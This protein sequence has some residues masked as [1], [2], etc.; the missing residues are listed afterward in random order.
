[1]NANLVMAVFTVISSILPNQRPNVMVVIT[2]NLVL[3]DLIPYTSGMQPAFPTIAAFTDITLV[4]RHF[5]FELPENT[6]K[7]ALP[8]YI[9]TW[10][11]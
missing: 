2:A 4:S 10:V 1:M 7:W 9:I 11:R 5:T 8:T 6:R 3:I